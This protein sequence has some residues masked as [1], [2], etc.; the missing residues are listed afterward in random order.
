MINVIGHTVLLSFRRMLIISQCETIRKKPEKKKKIIIVIINGAHSEPIWRP[1]IQHGRT[2]NNSQ[3]KDGLE[4][5][6]AAF[7]SYDTGNENFSPLP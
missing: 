4:R 1:M 5:R 7:G 2:I 3:V 6:A